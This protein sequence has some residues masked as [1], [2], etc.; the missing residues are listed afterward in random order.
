MLLTLS[1]HGRGTGV[2]V[3]PFLL[4]I[5]WAV[6]ILKVSRKQPPEVFCKKRCS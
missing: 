3:A 4:R 2:F 6:H 5:T 1:T